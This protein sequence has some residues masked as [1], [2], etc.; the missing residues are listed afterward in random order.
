MKLRSTTPSIFSVSLVPWFVILAMLAVVF[1]GCFYQ[2]QATSATSTKTTEQKIADLNKQIDISN[3]KV[4]TVG[5]KSG[6]LT[7]KIADLK[8]KRQDLENSISEGQRDQSSLIRS[9]SKTKIELEH[10]KRALGAI[11]AD[12]YVES[13]ISPIEMLAGS[14]SIGEYM[15]RQMHYDSINDALSERVDTMKNTQKKLANQE[16]RLAK[17]LASQHK[18]VSRVVA[19]QN[20]HTGQLVA[21]EGES[22][23]LTK[24][25]KKMIA[26]RKKLQDQQQGLIASS[27]AG[28]EMVS[29]GTLALTDSLAE[30]VETPSPQPS[31]APAPKTDDTPKSIESPKPK[32]KDPAPAP[33]PAP[34]PKPKPKPKPVVLPNGGYPA[35]LMNCRV[36]ANAFSYGYDAWGYGCRQ[37]VSYAAW[38]MLE[39]TGRAPMYWGNAN[40]WPGK[41]R[42]NGYKTGTKPRA[43]SIGVMN[44]G[45]YGHVVWVESINANGTLNIS[46]YNAWLPNKPNGG[47]GWYSEYRGVS[48]SSYQTYIYV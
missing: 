2:V 30:S 1:I 41:A 43:K 36:D 3:K 14:D 12:M 48:P 15:D 4:R 46:Q 10:S 29:P 32:P 13:S 44:I 42:A 5:D 38:K 33:A 24:L 45:Y 27:L 11:M 18:E 21:L 19:T 6:T 17:M 26:E 34:K 16:S 28:A 39:K 8:K 23:K 25:T 47:W 22:G 35:H 37:C 20:S 9:I 7:D 31:L 40:Q